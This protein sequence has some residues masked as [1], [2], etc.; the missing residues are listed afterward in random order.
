[1]STADRTR[2]QRDVDLASE[3]GLL[4]LVRR[5]GE[6]GLDGLLDLLFDEVGRGTA[7][8][9]IARRQLAELLHELG[10]LA[11]LAQ[12]LRLRRTE[13][14]LVR[15]R[16]RLGEELVTELLELRDQFGGVSAF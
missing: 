6:P 12:E 13:R 5:S 3:I 15:E 8:G 14:L 4:L 11:L 7:L 10:D 9:A 16:L 2:R 1:M